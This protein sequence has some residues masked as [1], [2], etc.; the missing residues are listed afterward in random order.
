MAT[1]ENIYGPEATRFMAV[2]RAL[3]EDICRTSWRYTFMNLAAFDELCKRDSQTG[4]KVY[5]DEMLARAHLAA[6][7]SLVRSY[8]WLEGMKSAYEAGLFLPFCVSLRAFLES[9]VDTFHG[10]N[11]VALSLAEN[12][13]LIKRAIGGQCE[14]GTSQTSSRIS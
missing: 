5:W 6:T 11:G 12:H 13:M 4:M 9:A 10:L 8:R 14:E 7:T 1:H 2:V 3:V